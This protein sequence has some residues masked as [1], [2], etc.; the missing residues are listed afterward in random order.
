MKFIHLS[1]LHIGKRVNGFSMIEDQKHI[2]N[3]IYDICIS[4]QPQA[5]V[6][7]GDIYDKN[8]P[9][10]E[11]ITLFDDFLYRLAHN[12]F[13]VMLISGNHDSAEHISF[14]NRLMQAS[15]VYVSPAF[16]GNV[17]KVTLSDTSGDVNFYLLPY[18]ALAHVRAIYNNTNKNIQ[19]VT[20][21]IT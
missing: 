1:D 4:E 13:T 12:R 16:D 9:S 17:T 21:K 15:M 2:L 8:V 10:K 3:E 19:P 7:A 5:I 14:G 6:I 11:A 18:I 20:I